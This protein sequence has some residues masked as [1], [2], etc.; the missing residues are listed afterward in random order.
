MGSLFSRLQSYFS[1]EFA[2]RYLAIIL[3]EGFRYDA[4]PITRFLSKKFPKLHLPRKKKHLSLSS[5]WRFPGKDSQKR[6]DLVLLEGDTP[7]VLLEIKYSDNLMAAQLDDYLIYCKNNKCKFILLTRSLIESKDQLDIERAQQTHSYLCELAHEFRRSRSEVGKLIFD[8]FK[9]KGLVMNPVNERLLFNLLHHFL[10]PPTKSGRN[11][12]EDF[13]SGGAM[14][15]GAVLNNMRLLAA[16]VTPMIV[17]A[18]GKTSARQ[19]TI[20][21]WVDS[22][23]NRKKLAP[24]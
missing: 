23:F 9:E 8:Y 11:T 7:L 19:A 17:R 16:E 2:G 21:F 3:Q 1:A 5:E 12:S 15:L 6:A 10:N 24:Q 22:C 14:Q 18:T 4:E 13:V 20:D